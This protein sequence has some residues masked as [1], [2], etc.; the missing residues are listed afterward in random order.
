M[1]KDIVIDVNKIKSGPERPLLLRNSECTHYPVFNELIEAK[2]NISDILEA[3]MKEEISN[4]VKSNPGSFSVLDV[5]G[6]EVD[7]VSNL[8]VKQGAFDLVQIMATA[9]KAKRERKESEE[10]Q[11]D[12]QDAVKIFDDT[13]MKQVEKDVSRGPLVVDVDGKRLLLSN[14]KDLQNLPILCP[15]LTGEQAG[16][17]IKMGNQAFLSDVG[18]AEFLGS[19]GAKDILY[20]GDNQ[21][22][23]VTRAYLSITG[24]K[25][26]FV[27]TQQFRYNALDPEGSEYILG[28]D[29]TIIKA[30]QIV[31]ITSLRGDKFELGR[32]TGETSIKVVYSGAGMEKY[33]SILKQGL[34]EKYISNA[35][36]ALSQGN[37]DLNFIIETTRDRGGAFVKQAQQNP[38]SIESQSSK[39]EIEKRQNIS[40]QLLHQ[41]EAD[42]R[43]N[44]LQKLN[45]SKEFMASMMG[46]EYAKNTPLWQSWKACNENEKTNQLPNKDPNQ[47]QYQNKV[48][49]SVE[50]YSKLEQD[51]GKQLKYAAEKLL[52]YASTSQD[53]LKE[54]VQN[55]ISPILPEGSNISEKDSEMILRGTQESKS[56]PWKNRLVKIVD[57]VLTSTFGVAL[58]LVSKDV[59][60]LFNQVKAERKEKKSFVKELQAKRAHGPASKTSM[61][62]T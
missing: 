62:T 54:I 3:K 61:V 15:E 29:D 41:N 39:E 58:G 35:D 44:F 24:G 56:L 59:A 16:Y 26:Q 17:I 20:T 43:A 53:P 27:S 47:Y 52:E 25:V 7:K 34:Q 2:G 45:H 49:A 46:E 33:S 11:A 31:D 51:K 37:P 55:I 60:Q 12:I 14:M 38:E 50:I 22:S 48:S 30:S 19:L 18:S 40:D 32:A 6:D 4:Y 1:S 28:G 23:K 13:L 57:Q 10:I 36:I 21:D 8:R 5:P 9:L 42:K